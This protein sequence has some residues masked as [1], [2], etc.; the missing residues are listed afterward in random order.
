[1]KHVYK[2]QLLYEQLKQ[3]E[4]NWESTK[5]ETKQDWKVYLDAYDEKYS[6]VRELFFE[7][8]EQNHKHC[9]KCGDER[10]GTTLMGYVL[11]MRKMSEYEDRNTCTCSGCGDRHLFHDR[12]GSFEEK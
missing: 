5:P 3:N 12:V 1:M 2:A 6:S 4:E 11:D 10:Y 9:P 7:E 8:Y